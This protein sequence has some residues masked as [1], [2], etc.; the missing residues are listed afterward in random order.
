MDFGVAIFPTDTTLPLPDL[1]RAVEAAG[2]AALCVPEHTHIPV[3][4]TPWPGGAKLPPEY[5]RTFDPFVVLAAAAA[6]TEHLQLGTAICLVPQR[7]PIN[8]AKTVASLDLLSGGRFLFGVGAGWDRPETANHGVDPS[9]RFAVLAER[10][11]AM[12][13]IWANEVAS[14]DGEHVSFGPMWCWPK[15]VQEGP[16]GVGPPVLVGGNAE[17]A[18]QR[19][20][21]YGDGWMPIF[22]RNREKL[23]RRITDLR[24][25]AE[26]AG[27][28]RPSVTIYD[29][30]ADPAVL[31][32]LA[33]MG[34]DRCLFVLQPADPA[35]VLIQLRRDAQ[36]A[37]D[38]N[39]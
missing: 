2:F 31:T 15:P 20:L 27:L 13:A 14:F 34:V 23:A 29:A 8:T 37:K 38:F 1:A 19:V 32:E 16:R 22:G 3:N 36:V 7:D 25:R 21:D 24:E 9:E 33:D 11:A 26:Q 5:G 18:L 35:A 30:P 28:H 10:V 6:V 39:G 12:R 4:H 17:G